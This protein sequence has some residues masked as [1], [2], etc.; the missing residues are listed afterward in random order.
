MRILL[1]SR[2]YPPAIG[3]MQAYSKNLIIHLSRYHKVRTI[4]LRG[5][6]VKLFWFLPYAFSKAVF[7]AA[8]KDYDCLYLC[9]AAL[10]PIGFF[11]KRIFG[12]P[13]FITVHGLDITFD[14]Y[15]YQALVPRLIRTFNKVICVSNNTARE[16]A[17]R[18]INKSLCAFIPNGMDPAEYAIGMEPAKALNRLEAALG[19]DLDNKKILLT[20]GRLVKRKGVS[21]F[22]EHV[23]RNLSSGYV[24]M[25]V[26]DGP[27]RLNIS[28]LVQSLRLEKRVY[29]LGRLDKA[30]L[31]LLYNCAYLFVMPNQNVKNDP[32]GFGIV[33]IEA[34]SCG[35][36]SIV[37][38][39]DGIS[40]AVLE[41]K[42]GYLVKNNDAGL[43]I[44]KIE[45]SNFNKGNVK[46]ASMAFAWENI[47][48]RYDD[49]LK[50]ELCF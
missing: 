36:P 44:D 39:V 49:L 30:M 13:V 12:I 14:N 50:R 21:W 20:V 16:C 24:Y 47:I 6:Q 26:G 48:K 38:A 17:K 5:R 18:G 46:G 19:V 1:I 23:F 4:L 33:A 9:D 34:A 15:F 22:I 37:N 32:E 3:G 7:L 2:K 42:T 41:S 43:F 45:N 29:I 11:I 31:S 35:L 8:K 40:D 25:V 27:E 28:R 10:A